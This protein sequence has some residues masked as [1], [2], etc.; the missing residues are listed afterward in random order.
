M[1]EHPMD[2]TRDIVLPLEREEAWEVVCDPTAW[3][4]EHADLELVPGAEGT[5][6]E[7]VAIVEEVS[8]GERLTF[9]WGDDGAPL[10]RVELTLVDA[11]GGTRVTV[12]ESGYA[13][14]PVARALPHMRRALA[15]A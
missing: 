10:T 14:G 2:V 4:A 11:V 15:Y 12:V 7:R 13:A 9:W 1:K 3:L 6:D 8:P 5:L